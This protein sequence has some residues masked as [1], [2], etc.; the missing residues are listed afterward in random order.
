MVIRPERDDV[1][2][3]LIRKVEGHNLSA[4]LFDVERQDAR[5]STDIEDAFSCKVKIAKVGPDCAP[6]IPLA[7]DRAM[8]RH[9]HG[10]VEVALIER[11]DLTREGVRHR[12][13]AALDRIQHR[14]DPWSK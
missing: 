14:C 3:E 13:V 6:Q 2:V 4:L 1:P 5:G 10:V 12:L 8:A 11:S 7:L 9:I